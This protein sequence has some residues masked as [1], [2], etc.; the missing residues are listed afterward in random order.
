LFLRLHSQG[1]FMN[2]LLWGLWLFPFGLLVYRSGF[3]PRWIG[4][5]LMINCFGYVILSP[6]ALFF[7]AYYGIAFKL[8]QPVLFGE[9]A[10]ML[11]LL[12]KGAKVRPVEPVSAQM[13][14]A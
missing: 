7:P 9:V 1:I 14:P 5:W 12:I 6:I 4:I 3:L 2:E 13:K 10:I 8:A 11:W